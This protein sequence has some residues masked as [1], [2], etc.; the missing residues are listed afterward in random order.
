VSHSAHDVTAPSP[1]QLP[2]SEVSAQPRH[3]QVLRSWKQSAHVV[4]VAPAHGGAAVKRTGGKGAVTV[5]DL[6]Q[7]C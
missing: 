1:E 2:A 6:Q 4:T 7:I 5:G 3:V